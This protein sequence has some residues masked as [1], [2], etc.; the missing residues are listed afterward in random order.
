MKTYH[1]K[2]LSMNTPSMVPS[3]VIFQADSYADA[4]AETHR[5]WKN[6]ECNI[7]LYSETNGMTCWHYINYKG[8]AKDY[9]TNSG[10][11]AEQQL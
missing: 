5:T 1:L 11:S 2:V 4:V 10:V 7:G 8:L 9:N 6:K 3:K